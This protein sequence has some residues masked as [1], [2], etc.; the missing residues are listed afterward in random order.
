MSPSELEL[1]KLFRRHVSGGCCVLT[2]AVYLK[3]PLGVFSWQI[4]VE[5]LAITQLRSMIRGL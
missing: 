1:A 3:L 4:R 5:R 2:T